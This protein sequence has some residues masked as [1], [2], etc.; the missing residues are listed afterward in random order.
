MFMH[1]NCGKGFIILISLSTLLIHPFVSLIFW[2][3]IPSS[4][5]EA[6]NTF[7]FRLVYPFKYTMSSIHLA[8]VLGLDVRKASTSF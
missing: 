1:A 3:Q 7:L 8:W 5:C 4:N 6:K 2:N